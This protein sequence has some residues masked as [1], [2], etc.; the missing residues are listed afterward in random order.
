M[1][2]K[3]IVVNPKKE[4]ETERYYAN[5]FNIENEQTLILPKTHPDIVRLR[6][7]NE[8]LQK[9]TFAF[10]SPITRVYSNNDVI[11]G[12]RLYCAFQRLPDRRARIRINTLL[13]G[14]PCVEVDLSCNHPAMLMA[15]NGLQIPRDWYS[16]VASKANCN[17]NKV[18]FLVTRMIGAED[19]S[20]DLRPS[21]AKKNG[22]PITDIPS[23]CDRE[24]IEYVISTEFPQ[25][26]KSL[27][28][29]GIGVFLQNLEG[30][31]LLNAMDAL[32]NQE[33][34]SLPVH[35]SLCVQYIFE[36]EAKD[37]IEKSWM[38]VLGVDFKPWIKV[39]YSDHLPSKP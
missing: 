9:A 27:C 23:I 2:R 13:N 15:L 36:K 26:N 4:S 37:A 6:R 19:R 3:L 7:I 29:G 28:K 12:G 30:E 25:L 32:V 16:Y 18:K 24:Q 10:K 33:I 17:R 35:D 14:L 20:I 8:A 39:D 22:I 11:Q 1:K 5:T 21:T 34:L 38:D 31:I